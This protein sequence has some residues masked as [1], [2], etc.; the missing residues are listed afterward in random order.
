VFR[1]F[2]DVEW[3]SVNLGVFICTECASYHRSIGAKVSQVQHM[4]LNRWTEAE[5]RQL[6]QGGNVLSKAVYEAHV[7]LFYKRPNPESPR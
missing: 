4:H 3:A 2:A 7:P 1:F 6:E 5:V